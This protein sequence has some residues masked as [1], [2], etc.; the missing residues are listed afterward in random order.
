MKAKW[1]KIIFHFVLLF[2]ISGCTAGRFF[3]DGPKIHMGDWSVSEINSLLHEKNNQISPGNQTLLISNAFLGSPYLTQPLIGSAERREQLVVRFD[4]FD[5]MTFIESVEA[6]RLS[7]SFG[8]ITDN[9]RQTRYRHGNVGYLTRNHFF[10]DWTIYSHTVRDVTVQIGGGG[11]QCVDKVLNQK[12]DNSRYLRGYPLLPRRICFLPTEHIDPSVFAR[13]K[14]GD[15]VGFFS[16]KPG[17]DVSHVGIIIIKSG[18]IFL[19]HA[20][21]EPGVRKVVDA[22]FQPYLKN[23]PGIIVLR[24]ITH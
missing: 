23:H 12:D 5:C 1:T 11:H 4:G 10:S 9:L 8:E 21:S 3:V 2:S 13:L 22:E 20:S 18:R 16:L 7:N 6:L 17:L 15:Y 19:R 24:P 14:S